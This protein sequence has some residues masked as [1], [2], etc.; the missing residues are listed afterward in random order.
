VNIQYQTGAYRM[1]PA[2]NFLPLYLRFKLGKTRPVVVTTFHDLRVPYLFPKAGKART[3]V[4]QLLLKT[5]DR[6]ILTNP[7]DYQQAL[8]WGVNESR[9]RLV[10]IGSNI[11]AGANFPSELDRAVFR[12][13]LGLNENDFAIGYFG[14]VNR[15]KGL[16]TLLTALAGLVKEDRSFKLVII[17][18]E[19]G[20]T[21]ATNRA[22]AG[23]IAS[24]LEKLGLSEAVIRTGHQSAGETSRLFYA[25]D[26][27]ALP[28]RDGASFR[29]GSLL[30]PLAHGLPVI[31]TWPSSG[32]E[33]TGNL[34]GVA[35]E[36]QLLDG[37]N[38]LLVKPEDPAQLA[39][40][41]QRVRQEP[42]LRATL[43][44][45]AFALARHFSWPEIARRTLAIYIELFKA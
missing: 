35:G 41:I 29:R 24:L 16:D 42:E 12:R 6:A 8:A 11:E 10:P 13:G 17:G 44:S 26:A 28:F 9:L 14:L 45:G 22:Y 25:L 34:T 20:Q 1:H 37:R 4:N 18:G 33:P 7:T 39:E 21:D 5:S 3:W 43:Q 40:A 15:S 38:I 23:E 19:T 36:P 32:A 30:A 31:S 2:I 27:V